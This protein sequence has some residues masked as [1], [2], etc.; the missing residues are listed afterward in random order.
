MLHCTHLWP[1][2]HTSCCH[3]SCRQPRCRH[4]HPCRHR[5]VMRRLHVRNMML[6]VLL[7]LQPLLGEYRCCCCHRVCAAQPPTSSAPAAPRSRI[8]P[9]RPSRP[10]CHRQLRG[11]W[12]V[13][14]STRPDMELPIE[15]YHLSDGFETCQYLV[16]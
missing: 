13:G 8:R 6:H 16:G 4:R 7:L 1:R 9:H 15:S 11:L 3:T 14:A 12:Q 2:R 10:H 5:H